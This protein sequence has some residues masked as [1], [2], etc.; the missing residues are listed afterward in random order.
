MLISNS[1]VRLRL[2]YQGEIHIDH[3]PSY[4]HNL[5]SQF[6][7]EFPIETSIYNGFSH[8]FSHDVHIQTSICSGFSHVFPMFLVHFWRPPGHPFVAFR[9]FTSIT[10]RR[11][12][13]ARCATPAMT[14]SASRGAVGEVFFFPLIFFV[15]NVCFFV[16]V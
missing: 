6:S 7:H 11:R 9:E 2:V 10:S 14:L 13:W 3:C 12:A 4:K 16:F 5:D 15:F 8:I 1:Y